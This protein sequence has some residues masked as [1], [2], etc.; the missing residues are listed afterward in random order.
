MSVALGGR[1]ALS[2]ASFVAAPG[3]FLVALGPNGAGKTS[4][5]RALAG[6]ARASGTVRLGEVDLARLTPR[7]RARRLAWL[8]QAGATHWP[9][10]ARDIVAL[11]RMPFGAPGGRLSAA[12]RAVVERVMAA[13]DVTPI[14]DR[15]VTE[16]SGGER[17]RVLLARALAVEAELLL[18]DEPVAALDP[19]H[20]L[21]VMRLLADEARAGR[22]VLAVLH[23]VG[24]ALRSADRLLLL[25]AGRLVADRPTGEAFADD[26]LDRVFGVNFRHAP[27]PTGP[28]VAAT[29]AS[30]AG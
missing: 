11:G 15:P 17:A 28:L 19:A 10:P 9:L 12:D 3:E 26:A 27:G 22:I 7:E 8:P 13:C 29:P 25:E 23:D 21:M 6:L 2:E 4:L 18:V 20:Q 16:L 30:P 24:L 14:A 1:P 5:L